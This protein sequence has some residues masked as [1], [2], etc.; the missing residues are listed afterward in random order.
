MSERRCG[1]LQAVRAADL[2]QALL[3]LPFADALRLFEHV[4]AW[5]QGGSQVLA[6]VAQRNC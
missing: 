6:I 5:L 4:L 1:G 3:V 2:E